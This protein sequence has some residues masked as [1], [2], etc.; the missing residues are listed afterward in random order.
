M[1]GVRFQ[2][3]GQFKKAQWVERKVQG[4]GTREKQLGGLEAWGVCKQRATS[5]GQRTFN[6][7]FAIYDR[8]LQERARVRYQ[9]PFRIFE[10]L[11]FGFIWNLVI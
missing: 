9:V 5:R 4:Q 6:R 11:Y 10:N 3:E 1:S 8:L 2:E 7:I